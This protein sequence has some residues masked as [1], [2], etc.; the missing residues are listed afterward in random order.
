MEMTVEKEVIP[1]TRHHGIFNARGGEAALRHAPPARSLEIPKDDDFSNLLLEDEPT[2]A[3]LCVFIRDDYLCVSHGLNLLQEHVGMSE[4]YLKQWQPRID[5][6]L[7]CV[8]AERG[9]ETPAAEMDVVALIRNWELIGN[10]A[11]FRLR[12]YRFALAALKGLRNGIIYGTRTR[13]PHALVTVLLFG[14]GTALTSTWLYFL[15]DNAMDV[16][17]GIC[18]VNATCTIGYRREWHSFLVAFIV[19]YLVFGDN[20]GV[21]MQINLYLLSRILVGLAR[22]GVEK[23]I[24]PTP[25]GPVFPWFAATVW[26]FVLWLFEHHQHVLQSSLRSS[27]IYLYRDSDKWTNIRNFLI[28]DD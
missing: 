22:L 3:C 11:L 5:L 4:K 10:Y 12:K 21:N 16:E 24:I 20:N 7:K 28:S 6:K 18:W 27:M 17:L 9:C 25:L 8:F 2:C 13:A 15:G 1:D 19:G 26:G 14:N 23:Q